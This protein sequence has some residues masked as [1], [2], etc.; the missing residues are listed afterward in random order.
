M[1]RFAFKFV[2]EILLL[3]KTTYIP[4]IHCL[5]DKCGNNLHFT[6]FLNIKIVPLGQIV[7]SKNNR[8]GRYFNFKNYTPCNYKIC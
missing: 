6:L 8:S 2:T 3:M 5:F 7:L 1:I 4:H